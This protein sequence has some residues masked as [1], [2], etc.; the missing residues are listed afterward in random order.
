MKKYIVAVSGG[1]DSVTLLNLLV[2]NKLKGIK[3]SDPEGQLIVVH[4]NHGIRL[5]SD[6]TEQFVKK[7]AEG[8]NLKFIVKKLKLK[9]SG[10]SESRAE[11]YRVLTEAQKEVGAEAI[12][13]AHNLND[14][15]ETAII[16]Y[17]R[18][19]G[20][21]GYCSLTSTKD[22]IRP[23]LNLSRAEIS[24]IAAQQNLTWHE[25]STNSDEGYLRNYIRKS[26]I[27]RF[28]Q[29]ELKDLNILIN[30]F[31]QLKLSVDQIFDELLEKEKEG[32]SFKR[33][34]ITSLG[35]DEKLLSELLIYILP[36][37]KATYDRKVIEALTGFCLSS[38]SG[39]KFL[40]AG[41]NAV[42]WCQREGGDYIIKFNE[43]TCR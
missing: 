14:K 22:I 33:S 2:S 36:R 3:L 37:L 11:R 16:N 41:N 30:Q 19:T 12:I 42:I 32:Y 7:L 10:E 35:F 43:G 38:A 25:D 21:R 39:K 34:Q 24:R 27:P 15:L 4:V 6:K 13:T 26:V 9:G 20:W 17:I 18:G 29:Q 28:N 1:L 8:Y 5:D 40:Q 23:I 31:E